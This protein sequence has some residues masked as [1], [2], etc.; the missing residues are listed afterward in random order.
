MRPRPAGGLPWSTCSIMSPQMVENGASAVAVGVT[1]WGR[2]RSGCPGRHNA[3]SV[4]AARRRISHESNI[5]TNYCRGKMR[6]HVWKK[7]SA[8]RT[9]A[10]IVSLAQNPGC[11]VHAQVPNRGVSGC[12]AQPSAGFDRPVSAMDAPKST[13]AMHHANL[14]QCDRNS[15][16]I[17]SKVDPYRLLFLSLFSM[18]GNIPKRRLCYVESRA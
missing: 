4:R 7:A 12:A 6:H 8:G 1:Y 18:M 11:D 16:L 15:Q 17:R 14:K 13:F 5:V 3:G 9:G 10:Y 2:R